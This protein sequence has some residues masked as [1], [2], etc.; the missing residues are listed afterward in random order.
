MMTSVLDRELARLRSMTAS[1]KVAIMNSL[2]RQAWALKAAGL[3]AQ[4][5]DWTP[6]QVEAGVRETFLHDTP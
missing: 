6:E 4:H 3:R 1:E 2:W 5:P